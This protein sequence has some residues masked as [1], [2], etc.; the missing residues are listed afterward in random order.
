MLGDKEMC[1]YWTCEK[2]YFI[3][4]LAEYL[5]GE[6]MTIV[7]QNIYWNIFLSGLSLIEK[8]AKA[9]VKWSNDIYDLIAALS[10]LH[11]CDPVVKVVLG[12]SL[13]HIDNHLIELIVEISASFTVK[14]Q[15]CVP[16][17]NPIDGHE[18]AMRWDAEHR[19]ETVFLVWV[20]QFVDAN[21]SLNYL[22]SELCLDFLSH[23][24]NW[25]P[26]HS[27]KDATI[28]GGSNKFEVTVAGLL[29]H[30]DVED[31]HLLDIIV[32]KPQDIIEAVH[33]S[34]SDTGHQWTE[35]TRNAV[36]SVTQG[37]VLVNIVR[38]LKAD[39]LMFK[40]DWVQHDEHLCRLWCA[41]TESL[42]SWEVNHTRVELIRVL[43]VRD[44]DPI[45]I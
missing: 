27:V 31:G 17:A 2:K 7:D 41:N 6:C 37:P 36:L 39:R 38:A 45:L 29:E 24:Y 32:K 4:D 11:R 5:Y 20:N 12:S 30:E 26:S 18:W 13:H 35:V 21:L 9:L 14:Q 33:F 34:I 1:K 44:L 10:V 22:T 15:R 3:C 43:D 8:Q 28:I 40:H 42:I 23:I 25:L 19:D 16:V